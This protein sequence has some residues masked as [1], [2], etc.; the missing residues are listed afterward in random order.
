MYILYYIISILGID[1]IYK[2]YC[3]LF[4]NYNF[5]WIQI[6]LKECIENPIFV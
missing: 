5:S 2:L 1:M 6:H 3:E 4:R